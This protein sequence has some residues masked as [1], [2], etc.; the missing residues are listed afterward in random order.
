MCRSL[1]LGEQVEVRDAT[2]EWVALAETLLSGGGVGEIGPDGGTFLQ[3]AAVEEDRKR[4]I[5]EDD[6]GVGGLLKK[7]AVGENFR[8]ASA[9]SD[10]GVALAESV[11]ES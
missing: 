9:E 4:S 11:G 2:V 1:V 3:D 7:E 10:D 5:E 6:G 8:D